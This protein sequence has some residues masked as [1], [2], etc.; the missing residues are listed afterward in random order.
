PTI[1]N[2]TLPTNQVFTITNRP[3][4]DTTPNPDM[5][6]RTRTWVMGNLEATSSRVAIDKR[7]DLIYR[8]KPT[9]LLIKVF[10]YPDQ[11]SSNWW[12]YGDMKVKNIQ[13]GGYFSKVHFQIYNG[14]VYRVIGAP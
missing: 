3:A 7:I 11:A 1:T 8:N 5:I 9:N 2:S 13:E 14:H 4:I 10:G 6:G 12:S